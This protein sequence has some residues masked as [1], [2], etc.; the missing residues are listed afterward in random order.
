[1]GNPFNQDTK[2]KSHKGESALL[3]CKI[4]TAKKGRREVVKRKADKK[5]QFFRLKDKMRGRRE[6]TER[7]R[8][9]GSKFIQI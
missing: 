9:L 8:K 4:L 5:T 2:S 1:M 3:S 6:N 7:G